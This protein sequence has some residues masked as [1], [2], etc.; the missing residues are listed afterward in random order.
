MAVVMTVFDRFHSFPRVCSNMHRVWILSALAAVIA[1]IGCGREKCL[2]STDCEGGFVCRTDRCVVLE[3]IG[4]DTCAD[5]EVCAAGRYIDIDPSKAFCTARCSVFNRC[6]EGRH[7][8]DGLCLASGEDTDVIQ[9]GDSG[10]PDADEPDSLEDRDNGGGDLPDDRLVDD[11][12]ADAPEDLPCEAGYCCKPKATRKCHIDDNVHY[13][14]S[15]GNPGEVVEFCECGCTAGACDC[16]PSCPACTTVAVNDGCI[17]IC[18]SNCDYVCVEDT[19][20]RP[21]C[22]GHNCGPDGCGGSCGTCKGSMVCNEL[23][24]NCIERCVFPDELP[25]SWGLS[26]VV[27]SK[28]VPA[29]ATEKTG[30]H[31]YTGDGVGDS[32]VTGLASQLNAPLADAIAEGRGLTA[33]E[34]DPST[35]AGNY[36]SF[37]LNVLSVNDTGAGTTPRRFWARLG[38]FNQETCLPL[39]MVTKA[40]ISGGV[41]T[42]GPFPGWMRGFGMDGLTSDGNSTL[43]FGLVDCFIRATV[44]VSADGISTDDAT[45]SCIM[46]REDFDAALNRMQEQCDIDPEYD[47]FC[48][49]LGVARS[50]AAMLFDLHV[51]S[52]GNYVNKSTENPGNACS[53]CKQV[54]FEPAEIVGYTAD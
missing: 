17:G 40:S 42:A 9:S 11:G 43:E 37:R 36:S 39:N 31:D 3:C 7:C 35:P 19:C 49:Y 28:R 22:A 18:E 2:D 15:C 33:V 4:Q 10:W 53:I 32:G 38:S 5:D 24:G 1:F 16:C 51:V 14:D 54:S 34:I 6:P 20:C 26:G 29:N 44:T 21:S 52:P 47:S 50:A 27:T 8:S 48:S 12:G 23:T 45:Y 46:I 41:L 13:F 30:C 25:S